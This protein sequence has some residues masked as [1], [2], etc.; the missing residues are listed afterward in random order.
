MLTSHAFDGPDA[1]LLNPGC[2]TRELWQFHQDQRFSQHTDMDKC[3]A[4]LN[5]LKKQKRN[6]EEEVNISSSSTINKEI[7]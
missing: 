6:S 2:Y 3:Q 5:I 4:K 7:N 1:F